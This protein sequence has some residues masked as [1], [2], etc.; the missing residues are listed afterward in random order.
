MGDMATEGQRMT[1]LEEVSKHPKRKT[2][3]AQAVRIL[4]WS[5]DA[6]NRY[7]PIPKYP[8]DKTHAHD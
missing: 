5:E 6:S 8:K 3:G 2:L 7:W 1:T 4:E